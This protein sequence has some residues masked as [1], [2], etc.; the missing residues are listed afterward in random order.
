VEHIGTYLIGCGKQ[1]EK[2][3]LVTEVLIQIRLPD[4][5]LVKG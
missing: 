1:P 5:D 3:S 4:G 2:V